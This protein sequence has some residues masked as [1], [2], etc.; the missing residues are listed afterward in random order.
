MKPVAVYVRI[1]TK[2]DKKDKDGNPIDKAGNVIA[3]DSKRSKQRL[4]SQIDDITARL[5]GREAVWYTENGESSALTSRPQWDRCCAALKRAEHDTLLIFAA[6][7]IG[8]W[9]PLEWLKFRI[10]CASWGVTIE[11][12]R[13]ADI[14]KFESVLDIMREVMEAESRSKW[15]RDHGNRIR[16]GLAVRRKAGLHVGRI[17]RHARTTVEKALEEV[18]GGKSIYKVAFDLGVPWSTVKWWVANRERA[19]DRQ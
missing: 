6:D 3:D 14:N 2:D 5:A 7:R 13:E 11:S 10:E 18:Y 16:S 12:L 19:L 15:L 9:S 17:P 4:D 1:S 8:R